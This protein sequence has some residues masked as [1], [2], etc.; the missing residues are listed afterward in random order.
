MKKQIVFSDYDGTI[1]I[2]EE[3]MLKNI[4]SIEEYRKLGGKFVIVTGRSK[5]SIGNVINKYN[6]PYDYI[7]SNNGAVIFDSDMVKIY[8]R[9]IT[10]D[11]SNRIVDYLKTKDNIEIFFYGDDDK[12]E[13]KGQD[14]LKLRIRTTDY[15]LAQTIE[16]E[17]NSI[18]KDDVKAH[19]DFPSMY[20]SDI[21]FV[22]IDVVS[23]NAGK[24]NA[25]KR[26]LDI[27][28]IEKEQV[29]TIGDGRNDIEMI[30]EYNGY[31]METAKDEVKKSASKIFK[32]VADA[33][34]YLKSIY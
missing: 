6:I 22:I 27:L 26:L 7:I 9:A 13:Y 5:K 28:N 20:Y 30:K 32:S 12:V 10:A 31:S 11:I 21:D 8:E 18:F 15:K 29:V 1:Y 19:S 33:L 2:T 16:S 14:L 24:E 34:E 17:I 25:I 3:D 4:N 23:K